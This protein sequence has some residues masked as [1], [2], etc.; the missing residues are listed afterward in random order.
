[1]KWSYEEEWKLRNL[2]QKCY[3]KMDVYHISAILT[4]IRMTF[5]DILLTQPRLISISKN[6]EI[7]HKN[8]Q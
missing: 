8:D 4:Q 3:H 6:L 7:V 1:M 2:G 5:Y